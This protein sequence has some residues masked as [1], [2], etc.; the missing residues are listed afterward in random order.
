MQ[1]STTGIDGYLQTVLM[2]SGFG[3]VDL[4]HAAVRVAGQVFQ[5]SYG[6]GSTRLFLVVDSVGGSAELSLNATSSATDEWLLDFSSLGGSVDLSAITR[7]RLFAR[8]IGA[9]GGSAELSY[10]LTRL[11]IVAV[12][13]P[14]TASLIALAVFAKHGRRRK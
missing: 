5:S 12:P 11:E 10:S 2:Y 14:S 3:S 9:G 1:V 4:T 13:A 7:F 6:S 8:A